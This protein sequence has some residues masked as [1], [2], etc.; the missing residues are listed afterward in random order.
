MS[1][2]KVNLEPGQV[3]CFIPSF[4]VEE[5]FPPLLWGAFICALLTVSLG[6]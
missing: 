5:F 3:D 2:V 4:N 6:S 1:E